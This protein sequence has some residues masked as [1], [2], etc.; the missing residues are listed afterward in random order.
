[1]K[2]LVPLIAILLGPADVVNGRRLFAR[3]QKYQDTPEASVISFA[4]GMLIEIAPENLY[5]YILKSPFKMQLSD[6]IFIFID[7][8]FLS[9]QVS[10]KT[11]F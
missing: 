9:V 8:P 10:F 4:K 3:D 5:V 11:Y 7:F 2:V 6:W 1:M